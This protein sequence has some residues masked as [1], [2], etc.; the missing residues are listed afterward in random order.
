MDDKNYSWK[1][2]KIRVKQ[3]RRHPIPNILQY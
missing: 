1:E 3:R 2:L